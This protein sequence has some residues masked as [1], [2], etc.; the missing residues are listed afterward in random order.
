MTTPDPTAA[1]QAAPEISEQ[2]AQAL[3]TSEASPEEHLILPEN[4]L[5]SVELDD[6]PP[7]LQAAARRLG[8][9]S[10]MPVQRHAIPY[11]LAHDRD[12]MVQSRTG[13]GKTG[14]FVLP[15]LL[16]ID[17]EINHCQV[18]ILVPTREL[19]QQVTREAERLSEGTGINVATVIGGVAYGPQLEAF[20]KGAHF[21]VG[22]P[23]RILDHLQQGSLDL[24]DLQILIFDEADKMLSMGFYPDMVQMK[25]FLPRERSSYMFSATYTASVL[26]LSREFLHHPGFLSLSRDR[27]AVDQIQHIVYEVDT[28]QKDTLLCRLVEIEAP[29]SAIIFCNTK[30]RVAYVTSILQRHGFNADAISADLNQKQREKVLLDLREG[31]LR[32]LVAT[33]LAGRGIDIPALSHVFLY[34]FPDDPE[35]Y[36]HRAGRTGRAGSDGICISLVAL[37][38][39]AE[40]ERTARKYSIN[41][42][43]RALP[44]GD[45]V[46]A[47]MVDRLVQ[48]IDMRLRAND[49]VQNKAQNRFLALAASLGADPDLHGIIAMLLNDYYQQSVHGN[50]PPQPS[51]NV[52]KAILARFDRPDRP[53]SEG[54]RREERDGKG[55]RGRGRGDRDKDRRGGSGGSSSRGERT[56]H[57]SYS[58]QSSPEAGSASPSAGAA[59]SGDGASG[60]GSRS[61]RRRRG[62]RGKGGPRETEGNGHEGSTATVERTKPASVDL[63][64][65]NFSAGAAGA[66]IEGRDHAAHN[67]SHPDDDTAGSNPAK[68]RTHRGSRGGKKKTT[69]SETSE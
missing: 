55:P 3:A 2:E 53:A 48:A 37:R 62:G 4:P 21:V 47:L 42:D 25:R 61:S 7:E 59:P 27:V 44:D 50:P 19:A 24:H 41:Y 8:W 33:D 63:D 64:N 16:R 67:T 9:P 20:R 58:S 56:S 35:N 52:A 39:M 45:E 14:A 23:G 22:T 68:R 5:P 13:S 11:L 49:H 65:L 32:F 38:E 26:S 29:V 43:R 34:D 1:P 57:Q 12:L 17:P 46:E 51:L 30:D 60:E 10:L 31:R 40:L 36:I 6:L 54:P 18:L 28:L 69:G 66:S 15:G